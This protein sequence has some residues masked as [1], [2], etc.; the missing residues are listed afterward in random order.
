[1]LQQTTVAAV[2]PYFA[3]F[4]AMLPELRALAEADEQLVLKLWEGLGYYRRARHLH[5]AAKQLVAKHGG[6]LPDDPDAWIALPGVGRYILGAVLSQAFDRRLPIVEANSLR[7]L[8]RLFG[9]RGDPREGEGKAWVWSTAEAMLPTKSVG[10]FNQALMELGALICTPTTPDCRHC[11]LSSHCVAKRE[12]LQLQIPPRARQPEVTRVNE[13]GVVIR[14]GSRVLLCQRRADSSRWQNMWEIPHAE[15]TAEEDEQEAA[16]RI[17]KEL[18]GIAVEPGAKILTV[19]HAVTRFAITLVCVEAKRKGGDFAAGFYQAGKWV[20]HDELTAYP[21]S[22]PQ[23]R[24]MNTLA[25]PAGR[26]RLT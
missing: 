10:D 20:T 2:V 11:P 26:R 9:Y 1:M 7:V 8:A 14:M 19:K 24:L 23:R 25:K 17:A 5:A 4:M 12:G 3:R 21:V 18:T 13:I 16:R 22:A 15:R 6:E